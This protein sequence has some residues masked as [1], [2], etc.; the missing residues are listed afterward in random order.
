MLRVVDRTPPGERGNIDSHFE[1]LH[2]CRRIDHRKLITSDL[3]I[4]NVAVDE[5]NWLPLGT[6]QSSS[7]SRVKADHS[8]GAGPVCKFTIEKV[9]WGVS[10]SFSNWRQGGDYSMYCCTVSRAGY[11]SLSSSLAVLRPCSFHWMMF[12]KCKDGEL[13]LPLPLPCIPFNSLSIQKLTDW[14]CFFELT[15]GK[16]PKVQAI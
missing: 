16:L 10:A 7:S 3:A 13:T 8:H 2:T 14:F 9:A 12:L 5:S 1:V 4:L 15:N 6:H 11:L